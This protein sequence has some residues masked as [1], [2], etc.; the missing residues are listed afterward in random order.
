[1]WGNTAMSVPDSSESFVALELA[2]IHRAITA[3]G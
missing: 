3:D 2:H 1:M